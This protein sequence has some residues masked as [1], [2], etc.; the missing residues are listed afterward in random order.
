MEKLKNTNPVDY[1][2]LRN[3]DEQ[4]ASIQEAEARYIETNNIDEYIVFW[5]S[6]WSNGGLK[7]EGSKWHF[8]LADLYIK[9]KRYEDA[10]KFLKMLK[11]EKPDY[12]DKAVSYMEKVEKLKA[13][14]TAQTKK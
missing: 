5:E 3:Q 10:M 12:K 7:F 4:F 6:I 8:E 1:L 13:K 11:K 14:G 2:I 9:E